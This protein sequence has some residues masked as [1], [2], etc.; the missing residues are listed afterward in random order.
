MN[1]YS[2]QTAPTAR[3][4]EF[5]HTVRVVFLKRTSYELDVLRVVIIKIEEFHS[6][7]PIK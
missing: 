2:V 6:R 4:K 1:P 7:N 3:Y 5:D